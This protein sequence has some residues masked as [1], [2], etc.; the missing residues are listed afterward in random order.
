M[1][2][3]NN[4]QHNPDNC[5]ELASG[6][7]QAH[8]DKFKPLSGVTFT[9]IEALVDNPQSVDKTQAQWLIPSTIKTRSWKE[10]QKSDSYWCLWADIDEN[11]PV[12]DEVEKV[13]VSIIGCARYEIYTSRSA[14]IDRQKC[15]ILIFL[16]SPL[17]SLDWKLSQECLNDALAAKGIKPDRANEGYG[18]LCYLP[19]RGEFYQSISNRAGQYFSPLEYFGEEIT[20]KIVELNDAE[21]LRKQRLEQSTLNRQQRLATGFKSPIDAFNN[22]YLVEDILLQAGYE[23]SGNTYRHPNSESGS[24]SAS[25]KNNRVNTLSHND[26]LYSAR[27]GAHDAFSAFCTLYHNGNEK[28]ALIDACNHWLT[29]NGKNWNEA[30]SLNKSPVIQQALENKPKPSPLEFL[31]KS[32]ANGESEKMYA[33]MQD[34]KYVLKDLAIVGQWTVFYAAPNTG[35]TLLTLW[36]L[37]ESINSGEINGKD[38]FYANC[39]DTFKG[40]AVKL[41]IAENVGF[42]MLIPS[43]NGFKA[44]NLLRVMAAMVEQGESNGKIII[45][46]TLKKFTD[47]MDKKMSSEFGFTA[48]AF[49]A[50]GGSIICLAHVNKHKG[51]DGKSISAGTSD[52]RDDADCCYTIEHLN[53]NEVGE[54]TINTVAFECNKSRGDVASQITFQYSTEKG[55]GYQYL[56]DSISRVSDEERK[57]SQQEAALVQQRENDDELIIIIRELINKSEYKKTDLIKK[58]I[59][60]SAE[61][62]RKVA[63]VI[64][65]WTGKHIDGGLWH[66]VTR[67]HNEKV[68]KLNIG[69]TNF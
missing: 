17:L 46:D 42:N 67:S 13:L 14:T 21:R 12:L 8:S 58:T 52:I 30:N 11:P 25:I 66:T 65:R 60:E 31:L 47:L 56:L 59:E 3:V 44:D 41:A 51:D 54:K 50:A 62:R 34:D 36:L 7:G 28:E 29:H 38:V 10:H 39:D 4:L 33:Q 63:A 49:V 53:K 6:F 37:C 23:A 40:G 68:F 43:I 32:C 26:P 35:K 16:D 15:R 55:K 24:Y 69:K 27:N 61:P 1:S 45:L 18:Q 9:S 22:A 20:A 48:R 2:M 64:K 19:N 57:K 5:T